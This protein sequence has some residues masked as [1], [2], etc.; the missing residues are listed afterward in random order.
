MTFAGTVLGSFSSGQGTLPLPKP[1]RVSRASKETKT[2]RILITSTILALTPIAALA[3]CQ[4]GE[5]ETAMSCAE[6]L[7]YDEES[8]TCVQPVG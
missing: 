8:K 3:Q 6:G 4:W 2:M 1:A 5:H 7:V